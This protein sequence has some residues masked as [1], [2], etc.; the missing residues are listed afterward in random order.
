VD[1]CSSLFFYFYYHIRVE[2]EGL[3]KKEVFYCI[4]N[5]FLILY[6]AE[7]V[8]GWLFYFILFCIRNGKAL[9]QPKKK[10]PKIPW[11]FFCFST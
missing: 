8:F 3:T 10:Y 7:A 9:G 6:T 4:D 1:K 11:R 5:R 2:R